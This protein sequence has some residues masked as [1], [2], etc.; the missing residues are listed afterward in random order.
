M[1]KNGGCFFQ[2]SL[3]P[4]DYVFLLSVCAIDN[5]GLV[6]VHINVATN[7]NVAGFITSLNNDDKDGLRETF[8]ING[9]AKEIMK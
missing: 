7:D 4:I 1:R 9:G 2:S 6:K 8:P 3:P 5:F